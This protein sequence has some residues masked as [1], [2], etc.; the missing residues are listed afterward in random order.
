MLIK[1]SKTNKFSFR[2]YLEKAN[3]EC[4]RKRPFDE[5]Y[6]FNGTYSPIDGMP[7]V[8]PVDSGDQLKQE[9]YRKKF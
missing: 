6:K 9:K 3:E 2:K 1:T 8:D 4:E 7:Q 5:V